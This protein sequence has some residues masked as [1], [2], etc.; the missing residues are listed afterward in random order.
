MKK[1]LTTFLLLILILPIYSQDISQK[2]ILEFDLN[3]DLDELKKV[4][5]GEKELRI[6]GVILTERINE[7]KNIDTLTVK[8]CLPLILKHKLYNSDF[9]KSAVKKDYA[10]KRDK[11]IQFN[12]LLILENIDKIDYGIILFCSTAS[13]SCDKFLTDLNS[14]IGIQFLKKNKLYYYDLFKKEQFDY[15]VKKQ[16]ELL[17]SNAQPHF[18]V[19]KNGKIINDFI[20]YSKLSELFSKLNN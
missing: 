8:N 17:D 12:D 19:M 1:I 5:Y 18:A 14:V 6:L 20:G 10:N 3:S 16:K 15:L 7:N 4:G 2:R 13:I 9:V 11:L